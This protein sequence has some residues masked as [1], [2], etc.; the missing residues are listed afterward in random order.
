MT[1][2]DRP[3][4]ADLAEWMKAPAATP[5]MELALAA[6]LEAQAAACWTAPYTAG[7]KIAAMRRAQR[8]LAARAAPLGSLDLGEFGAT[9]IPRWDADVETNESPYRRGGFA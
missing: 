2:V 6:A 4:A 3:T 5:D 7:L 8:I 1:I 9:P